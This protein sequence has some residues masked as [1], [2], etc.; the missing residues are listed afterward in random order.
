MIMRTPE[1]P[2]NTLITE[3]LRQARRDGY[4]LVSDRRG[5]Y[6]AMPMRPDLVA[7]STRRRASR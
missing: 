4:M 1:F 6:L 2:S 7:G 3:A 5:G